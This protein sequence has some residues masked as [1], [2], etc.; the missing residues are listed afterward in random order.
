MID[1]VG[2]TEDGKVWMDVLFKHEEQP[3]KIIITMDPEKAR[4]VSSSLVEAANEA[5][6]F[7][8]KIVGSN[9]NEGVTNVRDSGNLDSSGDEVD[10]S[11][12]SG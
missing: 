1:S 12:G 6:K 7:E 2:Y 8:Q 5:V 11:L 10:R 9:G 3:V 4:N